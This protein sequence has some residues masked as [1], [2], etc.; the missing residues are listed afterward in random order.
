[1]NKTDVSETK[2]SL[3]PWIFVGF[4][5]VLFA[6]NIVFVTLAYDSYSGLADEDPYGRGV[7]YNKN[8]AAEEAQMAMGWAVRLEKTRDDAGGLLRLHTAGQ[9][10]TPLARAGVIAKLYRPVIEGMDQNL[11]FADMG[12]GVFEARLDDVPKGNWE[13][14]VLIKAD[15]LSYRFSQRVIL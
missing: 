5:V 14:R 3:I 4:F 6:V 2:K 7:A 13:L 15:D 12:Q 1:M 9:D 8:L 10:G 11:T